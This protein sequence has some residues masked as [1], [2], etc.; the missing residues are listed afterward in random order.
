MFAGLRI[1]YAAHR[2]AHAILAGD[3]ADVRCEPPSALSY[4]GQ[5]ENYVPQLIRPFCWFLK[6]IPRTM[7]RIQLVQTCG[8]ASAF[9]ERD[10]QYRERPNAPRTWDSRKDDH[11]HQISTPTLTSPFDRLQAG[12]HVPFD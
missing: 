8:R 4:E 9:P 2:R 3:F 7:L 11:F 12:L 5:D 10:A 1:V 6:Q